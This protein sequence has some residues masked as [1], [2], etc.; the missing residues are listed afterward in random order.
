MFIAYVLVTIAA[1]VANAFIAG[2]DLARAEF[3][4]TNS[5]SVGVPESWLSALG[6]LKACG[7]AGLLLG[8][9]GLPLI[10]AAAALGLALFFTGALVTHL[11]ARNYA[12]GF[13]ALYLLLA[14]SS[15]V[16]YLA[17]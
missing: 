7:A 13:P 11:R 8:L 3:V 16:L 4:L 14:I 9:I 10:G 17:K 1:I 5:A 15:L 2:A 12:V 6:I